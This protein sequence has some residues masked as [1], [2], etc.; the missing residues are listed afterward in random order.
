MSPS[1]ST[2][3]PPAGRATAWLSEGL[4]SLVQRLPSLRTA[5]GF[6]FDVVIVGSG[7]G[8]A[9]AAAELAGAASG[10]RPLSVCVLERGREYLGG[11][12]PSRL[13]ELPRQVR[14]N[15]PRSPSP[16]GTRVG[17]YD[18][19][20]GADVHAVVASG[21][22]GGSLINAGVMALP[23]DAVFVEPAWPQALRG[24]VGAEA[25]SLLPLLAAQP[26]AGAAPPPKFKLLRTFGTGHRVEPLPLTVASGGA[27]QSSAQVAMAACHGCG[28]CASGCNHGA[29]QSL[30]LGLLASA[31]AAGARL[32]TGA[33]VQHLEPRPG[34]VRG[35]TLLLAYTDER[36]RRR[37]VNPPLI[38][39]T[40]R[41][42]ILAAGTLGSTE[43]LLRTARRRPDVRFSSRLGQGFSA[44]GDMLAMLSDTAQPA[45]A[46]ADEAVD[47]RRGAGRGIG[48]TITGMVDLRSGDPDTDMVVQD[49]A[50]PGP[51]A[52]V[53]A[54]LLTTAASFADLAEPDLRRHG[55]PGPDAA[56]VD[57]Q[58]LRH[59]LAVAVI[60]RDSAEGELR[61]PEGADGPMDD[62][63]LQVHWP[64]LRHDR[65]LAWRHE[66]LA[67]LLADSGLGGR[68]LA[69]PLSHLA[70]PGVARQFGL[71]AGPLMTVH[72]LGGCAMGETVAQGVVDP[73][74]RVFDPATPGAVHEGLVVLDGS[75]I[76]GSLGINPAL[77]IAAVALR[78]LV[79]L[80]AVWG[81]DAGTAAGRAAAAARRPVFRH[82]PVLEA[83]APTRIQVVERLCGDAFLGG[84]TPAHRRRIELTLCSVPTDVAALMRA[85]RPGLLEFDP[86]QS[87]VRVFRPGS[88]EP[89]PELPV[90][91]TLSLLTYAPSTAAGRCLAAVPQWLLA[92]GAGHALRR[93]LRGLPHLP[94]VLRAASRAGTVRT[95]TY[96]LHGVGIASPWHI[97]AVKRLHF[98]RGSSPWTQLSEATLKRF[99]GL[100]HPAEP[101]PVLRLDLPYLA[102]Q[103]VPLLRVVA[104]QDQ[105]T[106]LLD[107]A[108]LGLYLARALLP[109]HQW[110]LRL[111]EP[112]VPRQVERLPGPLPGLPA[113][114]IVEFLV[115]TRLPHGG[116]P[117]EARVRL[118]RYAATQAPGAPP[119]LL[120]HGY[121]ASGTT[122]AHPALRPGLAR[123]LAEAGHDTWVLDLRSSAGLPGAALPWP[124][125]QVGTEDIP[126]AVERV[127]ALTGRPHLDLVAHCM[128]S[129]MAFM[130]LLDDTAPR[131]RVGG[132]VLPLHRCIR[133][134]VMSQVGPVLRMSP[135][136][137][138][139]AFLLQALRRFLPL[140]GYTFRPEPRGPADALLD[141]LLATLP[142]PLQDTRRE[143][144]LPAP[145]R[146]M[147]WP[148][149][150]RRMDLLYGATFHLA[151]VDDAVLDHLDDF[152]G[153]PNMDT[154][155][156]AIH[157]AR[158][159]AIT[160]QAG[161]SRFIDAARIF[162]RLRFP[163]LHVHG[164]LNG[165]V[166][167]STQVELAR[168]FGPGRLG[169]GG[170]F[171]TRR[172][173]GLGHQDCLIGRDPQVL[174]AIEAFL[175]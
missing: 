1:A 166:D 151:Q 49:L 127:L 157:F 43:I 167:V 173:D 164:S 8:G 101:E 20:A 60:G 169:P 48:P 130:A 38:A 45:D 175:C 12:F 96:D 116:P 58:R 54:E 92:R 159:R 148:A 47:P 144:P 13:A 17:L 118:T 93:L 67:R 30:D 3:E 114:Q 23:L 174:H 110:S 138:G 46:L 21:L 87:C 100:H 19:R 112:S 168:L 140:A 86:A 59:A 61:W 25:R 53:F 71:G 109:I 74:G 143:A 26:L 6:H 165:L 146:P 66:R 171:E 63:I 82:V 37:Q 134:L 161:V 156:Q 75:I 79:G 107:V 84:G 51:L 76:P 119:V 2:A 81:L 97:Q 125:E 137:V 55:S 85:D 153:A 31:H 22:G 147:A 145:G 57:P 155:A 121:S 4:E 52:R 132:Q 111:P 162:E 113:P 103:G 50:V 141:R 29:K 44:N 28:D 163:M 149:T 135:G 42:V 88:D 105:P 128:G 73:L 104:Q 124:M 89:E 152:F 90:A 69:N 95:L 15:T 99:P 120:V 16:Q 94:H 136:N 72:P 70:P 7:Y 68:V 102:A 117:A 32:Y 35:W 11:M 123:V 33:T 106:A 78:A 40:A 172:F 56:A 139:R 5:E 34:A 129:A 98:R 9:V 18:V 160:D 39:V 131:V 80:R 77:T 122:F 170:T 65:R 36:L 154:L 27:L 62:G 150:R 91:G 115:P 64:A 142:Y 126:Q 158:C 10:G 83:P 24:G 41:R 108:A 133:R 14:F